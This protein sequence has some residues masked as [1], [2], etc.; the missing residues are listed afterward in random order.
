MEIKYLIWSY[1]HDQWWGPDKCGYTHSM[2]DAGRYSGT[3]AH[4]IVLESMLMEKLAIPE[5]YAYEWG[6]PT[7]HSYKG[8]VVNK[9]FHGGPWQ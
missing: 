9:N 6:P 2:E 4:Q 8:N 5:F 7:Y 1:D 3:E